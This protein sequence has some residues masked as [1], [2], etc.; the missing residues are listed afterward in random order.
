MGWNSAHYH[1]VLNHL[2]ILGTVFG[3]LLLLTARV[4]RNQELLHL[5][6]AIFAIVAV[7]TIP[8][9]LTGE[10]AE[11]V[12]DGLPGVSER[13]VEKH[14]DAALASS[15]AVWLLGVLSAYGLWRSRR[16][17]A[18]APWLVNICLLLGL[19]GSGLMLWTGALGGQIRHTEIRPLAPV[20]T[21]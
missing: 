20:P 19:L 16:V 5:C 2:P 10:A 1:L 11:G 15:I 12:V 21:E 17:P 6:L 4:R 3:L 7:L 14:Q 18:V 8:T 13:I 9:Y